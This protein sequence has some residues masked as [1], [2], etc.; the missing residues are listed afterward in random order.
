MFSF[1]KL[2][3]EIYAYFVLKTVE[4]CLL[5]GGGVKLGIKIIIHTAS[6]HKSVIV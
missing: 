3:N 1:F 4:L 5:G 2:K 6:Q